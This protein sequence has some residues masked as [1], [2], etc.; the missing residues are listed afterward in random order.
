MGK[1]PFTLPPG[2]LIA[3]L[4]IGYGIYLRIAQYAFNRSL[5]LDEAMLIYNV[6]GRDFIGLLQMLDYDQVAPFG[7][8]WLT[9]VLVIFLGKSEFVLRLFPLIAGI[10]SLLFYYYLARK[11]SSYQLI[12]VGVTMFALSYP[13]LRYSTEF[14]PYSSDVLFALILQDRK[15]VV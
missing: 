7:F 1:R 13:L 8:L 9:K 3:F 11:Y 5:W 10:L 14:K 15:S 2:S 6:S 4:F 12:M